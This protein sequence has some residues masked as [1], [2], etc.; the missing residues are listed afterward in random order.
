VKS[1]ERRAKVKLLIWLISRRQRLLFS[2]D[3]PVLGGARKRALIEFRFCGNN[4]AC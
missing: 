4:R 3:L 1:E 2:I